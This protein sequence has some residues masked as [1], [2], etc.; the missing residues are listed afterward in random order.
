MVVVNYWATWCGTCIAEMPELQ[1][2]HDNN[3]GKAVVIGINFELASADQLRKFLDDHSITYPVFTSNP[4]EQSELG[5]ITGLPT[6]FLVSP[7]GEVK[8][9]QVGSVTRKMIEKF[10]RKWESEQTEIEVVT[11]YH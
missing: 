9:R 7:R 2:F 8:A 1:N 11:L 6:T 5:M 4:A 3:T 10:I